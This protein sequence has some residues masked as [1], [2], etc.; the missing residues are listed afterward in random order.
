MQQKLFDQ[1]I[2]EFIKSQVKE[3]VFQQKLDHPKFLLGLSG[4]PDSVF[5]AYVLQSLFLDRVISFECVHINHGWREEALAEELFCCDLAVKLGIGIYV[6][7]AKDYSWIKNNGSLEEVGRKIRRAAFDKVAAKTNAS[8]VVLAHH[9]DDQL[10]TFFIKLLRGASLQSLGGMSII[11]E[12]KIYR[13]LLEVTKQ[14]ILEFL[15]SNN[16]TYCLDQSNES[17]VFLR[18]KIRLSL[19]PSLSKI[20]LRAKKK[21]LET[22]KLL[23]QESVVYRSL[24]QEKFKDLVDYDS[25]NDC[26]SVDLKKLLVLE[27]VLRLEII[28]LIVYKF[29]YCLAMSQGLILEIDKFLLCTKSKTHRIGALLFLK[30][31]NFLC[32]KKER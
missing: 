1:N 3:F 6:E 28:K 10:E 23:Q 21:I 19:L 18:N 32:I 26:Y 16:I 31:N 2:F 17:P 14:Q 5:L 4:G 20:D 7:N 27:K 9:A 8:M 13:P 11:S 24:L 30:A 22:M 25:V 15:D 29:N 12:K